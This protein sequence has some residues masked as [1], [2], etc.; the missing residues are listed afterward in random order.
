MD[1]LLSKAPVDGVV[2]C[3]PEVITDRVVMFDIEGI[4]PVPELAIPEV[5]LGNVFIGTVA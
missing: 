3:I 2:E 5:K 4:K 1:S